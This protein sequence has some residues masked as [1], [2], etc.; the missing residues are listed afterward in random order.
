M[1]SPRTLLS[2]LEEASC[3]LAGIVGIRKGELLFQEDLA[4]NLAIAKRLRELACPVDEVR[5]AATRLASRI[6]RRFFPGLIKLDRNGY[7][8]DAKGGL[9]RT[10]ESILAAQEYYNKK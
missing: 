2:E 10:D 1:K 7:F 3:R 9:H 4:A 8:S 6:E 5:V